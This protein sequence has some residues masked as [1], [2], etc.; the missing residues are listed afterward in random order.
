MYSGHDAGSTRTSLN[1]SQPLAVTNKQKSEI[2]EN[3]IASSS[4][5]DEHGIVIDD[6]TVT[7]KVRRCF[8]NTMCMPQNLLCFKV[9][10]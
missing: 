8:G 10:F 5:V 2:N 3:H 7:T 1:I 6:D 4:S 9:W